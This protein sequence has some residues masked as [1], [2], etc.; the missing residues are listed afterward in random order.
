MAK[1]PKPKGSS[2]GTNSSSKK[3]L[4]GRTKAA[5]IMKIGK[6]K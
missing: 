5:K 6:K 2:K 3:A 1:T 4:D